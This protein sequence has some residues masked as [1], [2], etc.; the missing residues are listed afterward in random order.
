MAHEEI[1][2]QTANREPQ[3][4]GGTA[5]IETF[6][7]QMNVLDSELAGATLSEAGFNVKAANASGRGMGEADVIMVNTC[8]VR[9]H[10]EQKAYS[11]L[12]RAFRLKKQNPNLV[13]AVLGCMALVSGVG[14]PEAGRRRGN[15]RTQ[16]GGA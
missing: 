6:G 12:G 3:T 5:F 11:F 13:I 1:S 16:N 4:A 2:L 7:C 8:S 10:A 9:E 15:Q 14:P